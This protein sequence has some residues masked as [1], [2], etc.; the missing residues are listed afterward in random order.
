[1]KTIIGV[2]HPGAAGNLTS[3][4]R[5]LNDAGTNPIFITESKHFEKVDKIIIPGVG[6]FYQFMSRLCLAVVLLFLL[7][8]IEGSVYRNPYI[9][10]LRYFCPCCSGLCVF[11]YIP[12][13]I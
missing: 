11:E 8:D 4:E 12:S 3:V 13:P 1:M 6:G 9:F 10:I 7:I 5:A 2:V